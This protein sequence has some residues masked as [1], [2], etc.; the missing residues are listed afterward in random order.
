V[1]RPDGAHLDDLAVEQLD[2]IVLPQDAGLGHPVV[3]L[4][5]EAA[6]RER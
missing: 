4:D 5:R 1:R 3:F 2:A 6:L